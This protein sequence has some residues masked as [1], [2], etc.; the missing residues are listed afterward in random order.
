MSRVCKKQVDHI[1]NATLC[2]NNVRP[3]TW[4]H[5]TMMTKFE[6]CEFRKGVRWC[7]LFSPEGCRVWDIL[8]PKNVTKIRHNILHVRCV[9]V[10][11][12]ANFLHVVDHHT[13]RTKLRVRP[14]FSR[15]V[16]IS[17]ATASAWTSKLGHPFILAVQSQPRTIG[18]IHP[19]SSV[20]TA[21]DRT[22]IHPCSSV[23]TANTSHSFWSRIVT[24]ALG[25]H[26]PR[27]RKVF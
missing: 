11:V 6:G 4:N 15:V 1:M 26:F 20:T 25:C 12:L 24:C 7:V 9:C 22:P 19:C 5:F 21:N 13:V 23:T 18:P 16:A 17:R 10:C 2:L 3:R 8:N 14:P 27:V